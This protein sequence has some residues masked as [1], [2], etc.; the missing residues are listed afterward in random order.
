MIL[1]LLLNLAHQQA[2]PIFLNVTCEVLTNTAENDTIKS[3]DYL[4]F[5]IVHFH[6]HFVE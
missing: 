3:T 1:N 5:I 4:I 2:S 6:S